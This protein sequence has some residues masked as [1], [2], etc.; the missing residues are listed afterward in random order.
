[1]STSSFSQVLRTIR[2]IA[3]AMVLVVAISFAVQMLRQ[4]PPAR[5]EVLIGGPFTLT[6][7]DGKTV[8]EADFLGKPMLVY[9]GYSYCPDVCPFAL[10]MMASAL[11][12]LGEDKGRIQPVF[13]SVDPERDTPE[14]LAQYVRSASFPDGLIGLTGTPE[15]IKAMAGNYA[16]YYKKVGEGDDYIMDHTSAMFLMD[17]KGKYVAVFTHSSSV[18]DIAKCLRRHLDG[19]SC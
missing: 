3:A 12:T 15:Q 16:V 11:D 2:W 19:K 1:M 14:N 18:D 4:K 17:K 6:D 5:S 13:V 7:Q 8:T 10:Q 9:F